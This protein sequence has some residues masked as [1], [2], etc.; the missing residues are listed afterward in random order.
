MFIR[1]TK[2]TNPV[3]KKIY[4]NFQLVESYRTERGPR[5]RILLGLGADLPLD[6]HECKTLANRIEEFLKGIQSLI[7]PEEKIESLA[8]KYAT[9]LQQK[10]ISAPTAPSPTV[11][12]RDLETI[13]INTIEQQDVRTVG[14]E[15][16]LFHLAKRL[17]LHN[18][19]KELGLSDREVALGLGAIIGRA[20]VPGSERAT[21]HWLC[22]RSGLGDF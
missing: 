17:N 10:L 19:L 13:D 3:T 11:S 18:K 16:L 7:V 8:Q 14:N 1:K 21:H 9:Q 12:D 2:I 5:Q 6:T 15:H 20:T 22:T 4:W